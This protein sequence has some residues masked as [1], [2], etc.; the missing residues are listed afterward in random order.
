MWLI[1]EIIIV[2]DN[3]V[4][5]SFDFTMSALQKLSI[6]HN[7]RC[8]VLILYVRA[9]VFFIECSLFHTD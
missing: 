4:N 8:T 5:I 2:E 1:D 6:R 7:F 9:H 3:H